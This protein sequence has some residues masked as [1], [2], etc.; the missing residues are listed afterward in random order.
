MSPAKFCPVCDDVLEQGSPTM[1]VAGQT[2]HLY[3]SLEGGNVCEV[4]ACQ[5]W[6]CEHRGACIC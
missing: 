3:C 6:R 4:E 1:Q 2:I 5:F